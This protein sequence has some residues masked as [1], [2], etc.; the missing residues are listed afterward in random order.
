MPTDINIQSTVFLRIFFS[1]LQ[2]HLSILLTSHKYC[3]ATTAPIIGPIIPNIPSK[4]SRFPGRNFFKPKIN[5]SIFG[6]SPYCP[7]SYNY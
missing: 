1:S 6:S 4:S 7:F 3:I 5:P 2:K